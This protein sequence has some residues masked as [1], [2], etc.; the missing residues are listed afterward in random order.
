MLNSVYSDRRRTQV[1]HAV[2]VVAFDLLQTTTTTWATCIFHAVAVHAVLAL[3][4]TLQ[5]V[6]CIPSI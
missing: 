2:V 1:A 5:P 4:L 3:I 6:D